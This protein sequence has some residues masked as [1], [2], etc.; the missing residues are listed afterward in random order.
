M[1][2]DTVKFCPQ[3]G[4]A[5]VDFSVL[6]GSTARCRGCHWEGKDDELLIVP[7]QHEFTF[8]NASMLVEMMNDV[9]RLLA[10]ELGLP[11]LRFMLKWGFLEGN[12]DNLAGTLDRKKFAR[13]LAVIGHSILTAVI[14]E[15]T[16]QSEGKALQTKEKSDGAAS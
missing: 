5:S 3:C 16:K 2:N 1:T 7:I 15:R 14:L 6:A 10:G 4:S 12:I 8:G 11:Y 9:R 13:Y